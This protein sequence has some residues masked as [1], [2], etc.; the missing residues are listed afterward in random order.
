MPNPGADVRSIESLA[1]FRAELAEFADQA[2]A[3]LGT[4][5]MD[6]QRTS[7]W[8]DSQARHWQSQQ[9]QAEDF[10]IE[11][12]QILRRKRLMRIGGNPV[13]TTQEELVL[14]RA[15]AKLDYVEQKLERTKFWLRGLPDALLE[16]E[17]P[18]RQLSS[19]LEQQI[20]KMLAQL[21]HK[22]QVLEQ[23]QQGAS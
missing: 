14:R 11:A 8:L 23:Y 2:K 13:D 6:I 16:Y 22:L 9:R 17:G 12:Q 15:K 4:M 5:D 7:S 21:S 10:V 1:Q 19:M 20:P 3:A 18:A